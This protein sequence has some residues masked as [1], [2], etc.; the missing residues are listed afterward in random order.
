MLSY[1]CHSLHEPAH[2]IFS[3]RAWHWPILVEESGNPCDT[4][5]PIMLLGAHSA[6]H[7]GANRYPLF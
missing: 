2:N 1:S 7:T 6:V 3:D 5:C 4:E